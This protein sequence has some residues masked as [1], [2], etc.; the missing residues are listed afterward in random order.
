MNLSVIGLNHTTA[1]VAL[2][3]RVAFGAETLAAALRELIEVA[4]VQECMIL[5]TCNRTELHLATEGEDT[6]AVTDWLHRRFDLQA[7]TLTPY[8]YHHRGEAAV[9]HLMEVA[10]GLNS[11][12]L[13]EPQIL[14]Q[15]KDAWRAGR[16]AGTVRR[17]LEILMQQVFATAKKVRTE[18]AIGQNAVSVA[19][20]AVSL[21]RQFFGDLRDYTALLLGAGETIQLA[22][23]HLK[24]AGIGHQII[25]NR[26]FERAHTLAHEV[27]GFAIELDEIDRHLPEADLIIASTGAP[28]TLIQA[29]QLRTA[30][31]ARR[32]A[33]ILAVDIAVP[34]DIDPAAGELDDCYLYTVD[35]LQ[36]I[37]EQNKEKRAEAAEAARALI[38]AD[39]ERVM[40]RFRTMAAAAPVIRAFR[41][42]AETTARQSLED[43]LRRLRAGHDP[44]QVL[45]QL[46]TQLTHK[47]IHHPT[48][49]LRE[50]GET[51]DAGQLRMAARLLGLPMEE[52]EA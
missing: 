43:A 20:A 1:P 45:T 22:A 50:V 7:D 15:L 10:C 2:R 46:S 34:R 6:S 19:F 35:D 52:D 9:R 44:E 40:A 4:G 37:I 48:V 42:R 28:H 5:S 23:R 39:A 51:G 27:G 30:L 8:L 13:G 26:T 3:E 14:G 29:E 32:H 33:P 18:T 21:A 31:K 36:A 38:E 47:L 11:L 17:T 25:A 41:E 24:E 16:Q 49:A 12:V